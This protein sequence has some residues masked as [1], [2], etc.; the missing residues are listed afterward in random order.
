MKTLNDLKLC[1][2]SRKIVE[3]W[4]QEWLDLFIKQANGKQ[5]WPYR[6]DFENNDFFFFTDCKDILEKDPEA[7]G[8]ENNIAIR[9]RKRKVLLQLFVKTLME[10]KNICDTIKCGHCG[11]R[12]CWIEAL[13]DGNG[14]W[15]YCPKCKKLEIQVFPEGFDNCI[16]TIKREIAKN[17]KLQSAYPLPVLDVVPTPLLDGTHKLKINPKCKELIKE[18]QS[19]KYKYDKFEAALDEVEAIVRNKKCPKC[20]HLMTE[21]QIYLDTS[22]TP[23]DG[24][25]CPKCQFQIAKIK[26]NR[27]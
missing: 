2:K 4:L 11:F 20:K 14:H 16:N 12:P 5:G 6:A 25:H 3:D 18:I 27:L 10:K 15:T 22:L 7:K 8:Q 21:M 23:V 26:E 19:Y 24:Y 1:K 13:G 9:N 17:T